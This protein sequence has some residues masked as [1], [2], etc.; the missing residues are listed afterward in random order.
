[1][2]LQE[3]LELGARAENVLTTSTFVMDF[4]K[5]T[6]A[7]SFLLKTKLISQ[8]EACGLYYEAAVKFCNQLRETEIGFSQQFLDEF[9]DHY[10]KHH[11]F[12]ET[13]EEK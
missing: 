6:S 7:L 13:P 2:T 1:M 11:G 5:A 3:A 9:V 8:D 12:V 10:A 4:N